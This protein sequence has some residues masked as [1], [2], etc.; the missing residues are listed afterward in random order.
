VSALPQFVYRWTGEPVAFVEDW[1]L[2]DQQGRYFGW[3]ESDNSVWAA[4]GQFVGVLLDGKHVFR[5]T[6]EPPRR[7]KVARRSTAHQSV[8]TPM[9]VLQ[10]SAPLPPMYGWIDAFDLF[11]PVPARLKEPRA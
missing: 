8:A 9:E 5:N 2:F 11:F 6:T 7:P 3:I 10:K 1:N 4:S